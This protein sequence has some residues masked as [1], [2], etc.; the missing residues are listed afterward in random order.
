MGG[1]GALYGYATASI[2]YGA[3]AADP[4]ASL[5]T[6]RSVGGN[7]TG[8]MYAQNGGYAQYGNDGGS[9]VLHIQRDSNGTWWE[10]IGNSDMGIRQVQR[11]KC[12]MKHNIEPGN[13]G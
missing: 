10:S 6:D 9:A 3:A 8:A 2:T 7:D 11:I 5:Q 12:G 4:V 13:S 1:A